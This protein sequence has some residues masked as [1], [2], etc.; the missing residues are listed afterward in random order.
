MR[1][2]SRTLILTVAVSLTLQI[3]AASVFSVIA[4]VVGGRLEESPSDA[5]TLGLQSSHLAVFGAI[6]V[7]LI[8]LFIFTIIG[9]FRLEHASR[10]WRLLCWTSAAVDLTLALVLLSGLP[11]ALDVSDWSGRLLIAAILASTAYGLIRRLRSTG[12]LEVRNPS[13]SEAAR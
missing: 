12:R 4:F 10:W 13:T 1:N 11:K 7:V 3:I 5:E 2:T 8:I 9:T 6:A